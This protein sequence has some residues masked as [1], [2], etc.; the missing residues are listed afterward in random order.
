MM[1]MA[2]MIA[3][4][5]AV[6]LG[7]AVAACSLIEE[8]LPGATLS[9]SNVMSV[10]D[11]FGDG[12]IDAAQL[13]QQKAVTPEVRAFA[14][15]VL[16]EHR[17]LNDA[18]RHLAAELSVK[19]EAPALASHVAKAHKDAMRTLL[20]ASGP[21]FDRAYVNHEIQQHVRVFAF[22][23]AAAETETTAELK[24]ELV[25]TGPDLLSHI[26]AARALA[27][28]LGADSPKAVASR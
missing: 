14:A 8:T 21:A 23:Q 20:A 10:L 3:V 24:Q 4:L 1:R 5:T 16:K 26:S 18:N 9:D 22:L 2:N 27:R 15:R 17:E 11:S 7:A 13:A 19:P 12:E 25:R 28:Q 6:A